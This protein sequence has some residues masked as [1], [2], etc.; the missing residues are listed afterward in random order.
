MSLLLAD[1]SLAERANVAERLQRPCRRGHDRTYYRLFR[2]G[3][4]IGICCMDCHM[5]VRHTKPTAQPRSTYGPVVIEALRQAAAAGLSQR[6]AAAKF[7]LPIGTVA[8]YNT[9]FN[10]RFHAKGGRPRCQPT[11][12]ASAPTATTPGNA[13]V[14]LGATATLAPKHEKLRGAKLNA[15]HAPTPSACQTQSASANASA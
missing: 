9:K 6:Q 12:N 15:Q 4:Y 14:P 13:D 7:C 5:L 2:N 11:A 8:N 1:L 3:P 10:I